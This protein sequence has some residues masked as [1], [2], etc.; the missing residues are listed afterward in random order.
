MTSLPQT[1]RA[2]VLT[3]HGSPPTLHDIPLPTATQGSALV[4]IVHSS[5]ISYMSEVY[6][7]RKRPYPYPLPLVPGTS[8]I[9]RIVSVGPDATTLRPG[10][11]VH[12]NCLIRGRDDPS[13]MILQGLSEGFT[14]GSRKLIQGEWRDGTFA[15][16]AKV[17]LENCFVLDEARLCGSGG[18]GYN[19]AQLTYI[20]AL[21]VPYGGL[22]DIGLQAGETVIVAPATGAFGGAAVMVAL[23]MGARV[24]AMGRNVEKLKKVANVYGGGGASDGRVEIV[25]IMGDVQQE[26]AALSA[27]GPV[28]AFFDISPP[29]AGQSTHLKSAIAALRHGGRVSMMGGITGDVGFPYAQLM[30]RNIQLKGKWMYERDDIVALIQMVRLGVLKLDKVEVMGEFAL[31]DWEKAFE[32]AAQNANIGQ[33]TMFSP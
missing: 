5:I 4:R 2:L 11:L 22:R 28:D 7:S 25:P 6:V 30:F 14:D 13:A 8:A 31:A 17:P 16:Y 27:F 23:A 32:V 10:Q 20:S 33:V 1:H 15:E 29:E 24:I 9:G 21:L 26:T 19:Y 18:L 12:I 3:Q